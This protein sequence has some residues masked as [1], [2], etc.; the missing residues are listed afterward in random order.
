MDI[1]ITKQVT[2]SDIKEIYERLKR[3]NL[4]NREESENVPIGVSLKINMVKKQLD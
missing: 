4:S 3:F 2:D 1:R